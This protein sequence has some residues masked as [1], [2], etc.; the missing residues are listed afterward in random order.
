MAFSSRTEVEFKDNLKE[1]LDFLDEDFFLDDKIGS[2]CLDSVAKKAEE[3]IKLFPCVICPKICKSKQGLSRHAN[4]IHKVN[5]G[6]IVNIAHE[7]LGPKVY[8]KLVNDA[9]AKFSCDDY[10]SPEINQCFGALSWTQEELFWISMVMGKTST[11]HFTT[12][13]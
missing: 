11:Q 2:S 13:S 4:T 3:E 8:W 1:I 9:A 6:T 12:F 10:Y 5:T 7:K